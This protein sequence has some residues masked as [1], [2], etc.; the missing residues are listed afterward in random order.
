MTIINPPNNFENVNMRYIAGELEGLKKV[1]SYL[2]DGE[3]EAF[4][5][6]LFIKSNYKQWGA[7]LA[8]LKRNNIKGKKLV[9]MFQN[10]SPDGGGYHMGTEFILS[11]LKGMKTGTTATKIDELF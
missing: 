9:E 10:E 4:N 3:L 2:Y 6:I 5:I 7:M 1:I 8:Y 11:R